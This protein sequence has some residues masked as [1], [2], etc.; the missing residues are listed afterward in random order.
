MKWIKFLNNCKIPYYVYK[1]NK[2]D[3]III[4]D[5][6]CSKH[7]IIIILHGSIY[8]MKIFAN[9]NLIPIVI[10][11]KNSIFST[12][13]INSQFYY[14][15]IA[16]EKTYVLTIKLKTKHKLSNQLMLNILEGYQKTLN[17]HQIMTEAINQKYKKDRV[18]YIILILFFQFGTINNKQVRLPFKISQ[19]NL[20]Q[21]TGTSKETINKIT[22]EVN[23]KF[24]ISYCKKKSIQIDNIFNLTEK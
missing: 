18:L 19:K 9:K 21:I 11:N 17:S 13:N 16:L 23:Q 6:Y 2:N 15:L 22:R 5:Q 24:N 12:S 3:S 7:Q 1:L 10:L 20:A 8:I 4:C 14:Q